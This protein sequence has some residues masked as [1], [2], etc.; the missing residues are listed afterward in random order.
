MSGSAGLH[1]PT[2]LARFL[3]TDKTTRRLIAAPRRL[4]KSRADAHAAHTDAHVVNAVA[5]HDVLA[6]AHAVAI[7]DAGA[8]HAEALVVHA[9]ATHDALAMHAG[10][11][12]V[13]ADV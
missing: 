8:V 7:Y 1:P 5:I 2:T 6:G 4:S 9:V 3:F 13:R 11:L 12:A 10:A